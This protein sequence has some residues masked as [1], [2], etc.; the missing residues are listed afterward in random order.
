MLPKRLGL[1]VPSSNTTM[2]TELSEM[3]SRRVRLVPEERFAFHSSRMW[4]L[5]V[6]S[7]ALLQMDRDSNRCVVELAAAQCEAVA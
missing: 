3:F 4:M 2:E 7:E 5:H 1:I 6:T